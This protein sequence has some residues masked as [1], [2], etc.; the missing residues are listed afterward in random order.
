MHKNNQI[1]NNKKD[2]KHPIKKK[3]SEFKEGI[4][5]AATKIGIKDDKDN[6]NK[7]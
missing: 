6:I 7:E 2:E 1:I 3:I 4:S 5:K